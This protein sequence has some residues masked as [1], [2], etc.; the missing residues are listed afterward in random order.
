MDD[1][2]LISIPKFSKS[3]KRFVDKRAI[4]AYIAQ[5]DNVCPNW[6][7]WGKCWEPNETAIA[8]ALHESAEKLILRYK[9]KATRNCKW[10]S[11]DK[12]P[13]DFETKTWVQGMPEYTELKFEFTRNE[14]GKPVLEYKLFLKRYHCRKKRLTMMRFPI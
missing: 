6:E 8:Y 13:V 11:S 1:T 12:T 2:F 4:S 5:A 7:P 3:L 14:Y 10:H 9:M